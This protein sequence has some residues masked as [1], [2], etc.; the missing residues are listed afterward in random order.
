VTYAGKHSGE[1]SV[2]LAVAAQQPVVPI[3]LMC[4]THAL[5]AQGSSDILP[6]AS[7]HR[8]IPSPDVVDEPGEIRRRAQ[9]RLDRSCLGEGRERIAKAIVGTQ[10]QALDQPTTLVN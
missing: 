2:P 10:M 9:H 1:A 4:A 8:H 5:Q 7:L 6:L 3:S